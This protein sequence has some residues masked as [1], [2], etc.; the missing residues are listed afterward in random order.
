MCRYRSGVDYLLVAA[1][2]HRAVEGHHRP[3][4]HCA[5]SRAGV[6][7]SDHPAQPGRSA[8]DRPYFADQH[9]YLIA[10]VLSYVCRNISQIR[11]VRA[12]SDQVQAD[13]PAVVEQ[14]PQAVEDSR[15]ADLTLV[16]G[17]EAEG[18]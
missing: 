1:G 9:G 2:D 14:L 3:S 15:S 16:E 7:R 5:R 4:R 17:V 10:E 12:G 18:D 11:I 6:Q 8:S 13:R